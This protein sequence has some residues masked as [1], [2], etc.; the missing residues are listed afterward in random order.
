LRTTGPFQGLH[1]IGCNIRHPQ[2]A[3]PP[4]YPTSKDSCV[5]LCGHAPTSR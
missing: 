3:G 2:A 4:A 1:F 5:V